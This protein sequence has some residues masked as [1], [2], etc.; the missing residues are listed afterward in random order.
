LKNNMNIEKKYIIKNATVIDGLGS[1]KFSAD[2]LVENGIIKEIGQLNN[3]DCHIIDAENNVVSPG[4][5]DVHSHDDIALIVY[6]EMDFKVMQGITTVINGN[7]GNNVIPRH[8]T[9][10]RWQTRYP[11][12]PIP[13]WN[14]YDEYMN[15][16]N[17]IKPSVNSAFMVGHGSVR[18]GSGL[19]NENRLPTNNEYDLMKGWIREGME[20]GAV[21]FS[22]GLIYEPGRYASSEEII[23]LTKE[24][25]KY[26]GVYCSHMRNE[27]DNLLL[28]IEETINIGQKSETSVEISHHKVSGKDNWGLSKSSLDMIHQARKNGINV[29]SDQYP[30]T[31]GQSALFAI[32]QNNA[33]TDGKGGLGKVDGDKILIAHSPVNEEY[34][35]K[36]LSE[37]CD[38]FDL[39]EQEAAEKLL[40]TDPYILAVIESMC[41]EDLINIL[42]D[43]YTMIGSDGVPA[44]GANPHPRLY[45]CFPKI[46]GK[47]V[48]DEKL[49]S[50]EDAVYKMTGLP[51]KKF[52]L[53]DRG[54]IETGKV[55]DLV[56]FDPETIEDLATY[57]NPRVY[58]KGI[59]HVVVNGNFVVENSKH[60]GSRVGE[61]IKRS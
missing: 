52:N 56:I 54:T 47:Y 45:G 15:L 55:A 4:F 49:L 58:P 46:L 25:S 30:Y 33:F 34:E 43:P 53:N 8:G 17:S 28:S 60:T 61:I 20:A 6:P 26:K 14:S 29:H 23:E 27:G 18:N 1:E 3:I 40:S 38:E 48:R 37:I 2:I 13:E 16:I 32:H 35:G 51:A 24:I 9:L 7:C 11:D 50:L 42:L 57:D 21:G 41:D 39:P 10:E 36:K 5:I 12:N 59:K 22:T 44:S 19:K 31:A